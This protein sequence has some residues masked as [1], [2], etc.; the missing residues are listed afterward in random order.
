M[1]KDCER[2]GKKESVSTNFGYRFM[3][4]ECDEKAKRRETI[5]LVGIGVSI[6]L[7]FL[8]IRLLWAKVFYKDM[9]CALVECRIMK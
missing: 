9:R 4:D 8:G 1:K 3:C 5:I 7:V 2:C 6:L